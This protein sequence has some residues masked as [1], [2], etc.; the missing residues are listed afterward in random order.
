MKAKEK[1]KRYEQILNQIE[2][3]QDKYLWLMDFGKNSM[4]L[5]EQLRLDKFIVPGC[6]TRTWLV[7]GYMDNKKM[8]FSA[9]SDALISKG[10]VSLIAD[11]FSGS[12]TKEIKKFDLQ[13]FDI[14]H[15]DVLLTPG[16]RNGVHGMLQTIKSYGE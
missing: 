12:T 10:M 14:L 11:V 1:L 2:D 4:K 13:E 3:Q 6:Q 15:L 8:H 16:R 7:P 5:V 9:D